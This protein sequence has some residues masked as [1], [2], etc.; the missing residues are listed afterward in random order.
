MPMRVLLKEG[1]E[2]PSAASSLYIPQEP[3]TVFVTIAG[4]SARE[5]IVGDV[6]R[7]AV[8]R[9]LSSV[10]FKHNV[11]LTAMLKDLE[12]LA[13]A[14]SAYEVGSPIGL[15]I[16]ARGW[17]LDHSKATRVDRAKGLREGDTITVG[18]TISPREF[19]NARGRVVSIDGELVWVELDDGDRDRIE[20][21]TSSSVKV[22]TSLPLACVERVS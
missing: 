4:E 13:R 20:R 3:E 22:P 15:H 12:W 11:D 7:A 19:C 10:G 9:A 14:L 1:S 17:A 6:R 5:G 21:A 16:L 2:G 18:P 8:I